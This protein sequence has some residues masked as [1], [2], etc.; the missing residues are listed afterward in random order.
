[1]NNNSS[2]NTIVVN[3]VMY[4]RQDTI[5]VD[6]RPIAER[7]KSYEDACLVLGI[8]PAASLPDVNTILG[9]SKS[10][11]AFAKLIVITRALNEGWS[12]NW[13]DG[14]EYKYY[15]WFKMNNSGSGLSY[16]V[17]GLWYTY[18]GVPARLCFKSFELAE[19][20]GN[21]FIELYTEYFL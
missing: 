6:N 9:E 4:V 20:A 18:S 16:D 10:I 7:V 1:M 15:P 12:P 17:F 13:N 14:S 2:P 11:T 21:Q 5:A 3:G 19:Y 8:E